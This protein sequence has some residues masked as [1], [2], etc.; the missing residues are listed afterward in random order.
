MGTVKD[1]MECSDDT[2]DVSKDKKDKESLFGKILPRKKTTNNAE[3]YAYNIAKADRKLGEL[4]AQKTS[5]LA[6]ERGQELQNTLKVGNLR[7]QQMHL[8]AIID[9]MNDYVEIK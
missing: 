8:D 5:D 1:N 2:I 9:L 4:H 7:N 3:T 6:N